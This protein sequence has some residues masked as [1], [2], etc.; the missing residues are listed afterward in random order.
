MFTT[1]KRNVSRVREKLTGPRHGGRS[2]SCWACPRHYDMVSYGYERWRLSKF[3]E[4]LLRV[5]NSSSEVV[6]LAVHVV[7]DTAHV[8]ELKIGVQVDLDDTV[9][10]GVQVL[11][12]GG[13]R[14]TVED[15]ENGLVGLGAD[16]LLDVGLVLGQKLGMQLDVTG[17]VDTVH[18]SETAF[19]RVSKCRASVK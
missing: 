4:D 9:A 7:T 10:D 15:E 8:S 2:T 1:K 14:A 12:L 18:I 3:E 5:A 19:V 17:L 6:N 11:L 16:G 13:A